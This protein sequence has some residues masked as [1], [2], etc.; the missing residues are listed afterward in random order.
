M[1]GLAL[2]A[3]QIKTPKPDPSP[4]LKLTGTS[5]RQA[6]IANET[7]RIYVTARGPRQVLTQYGTMQPYFFS[8]HLRSDR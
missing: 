4:S 1:P 7:R 8:S 6:L 5:L 2:A 3:S